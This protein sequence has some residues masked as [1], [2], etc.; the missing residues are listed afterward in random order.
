M[1]VNG[2]DIT[3]ALVIPLVTVPLNSYPDAL[4]CLLRIGISV[5]TYL[6][7]SQGPV[8]ALNSSYGLRVTKGNTPMTYAQLR[9]SLLTDIQFFPLG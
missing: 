8:E 2:F 7:L 1:P 6:L 9:A 5:E 3:N 4:S